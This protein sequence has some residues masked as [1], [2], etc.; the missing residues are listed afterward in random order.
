M[1][2]AS[3]L[4]SPVWLVSLACVGAVGCTEGE[5]SEV[6][7]PPM[8][9]GP[10]DQTIDGVPFNSAA[11][12]DYLRSGA[13]KRW[14]GE[15]ARHPSTGP[16]GGDVRTFLSPGLWGSLQQGS[17]HPK[18]AT[19][20]KELYGSGDQVTGW[21]V[22]IKLAAD[23]DGGKQWYWYEVFS[24]EPG[25]RPGFAGKGLPLCSNCH[26]AGRDYVLTPVPLQ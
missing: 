13:Y 21:A 5:E 8:D 24:T 19:A 12:H 11:L 25:A 15:S 3:R 1:H 23:S 7:D 16:H 17:D 2:R 4:V 20:I 6:A 22:G 26:R 18:D 10:R 9:A 14:V